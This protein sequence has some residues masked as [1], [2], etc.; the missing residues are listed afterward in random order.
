VPEGENG[1]AHPTVGP[2]V[3]NGEG[4]FA[5]T[6]D[7]T[8][9][10]AGFWCVDVNWCYE[11]WTQEGRFDEPCASHNM[12][13][14]GGDCDPE[15]EAIPGKAGVTVPA[16]GVGCTTGVA[17]AIPGWVTDIYVECL[18]DGGWPAARDVAHEIG[19]LLGLGHVVLPGPSQTMI[20]A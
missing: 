1:N 15:Y 11:G 8:V 20:K 7:I 14:Y 18:R 5:N 16:G 12:R 13:S 10:D 4:Q 3:R 19:H 2:F 9:H 17:N 6:R